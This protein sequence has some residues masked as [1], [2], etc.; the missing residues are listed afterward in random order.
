MLAALA[1][2]EAAKGGPGTWATRATVFTLAG[3]LIVAG[4]FAGV[5]LFDLNLDLPSVAVLLPNLFVAGG[6]AVLFQAYKAG[7][8]VPPTAAALVTTL[9]GAYALLVV[10]GLP[11]LEQTRPTAIV[12]RR[13]EHLGG[14][15]T[16][17]GIY[18][19]ERWRAS[20]RYYLGRPVDRLETLDEVRQF[21]SADRPV[22]VVM[23]RREYDALR[24]LGLP[25]HVIM[26]RRAVT[27]TASGFPRKQRW[28]YLVVVTNVPRHAHR[29]ETGEILKP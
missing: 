5:V 29:F 26:R 21:L 8:R 18:R 1:W 23:I 10:I 28:G 7:W 2:R 6:A 15:G 16:P 25:V 17:V 12:A 3:L 24:R 19:L 14:I 9:V 13:L 4:G 20:I 27:G 22:Y 11:V